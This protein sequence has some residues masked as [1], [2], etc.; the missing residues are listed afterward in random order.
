MSTVSLKKIAEGEEQKKINGAQRFKNFF[1]DNFPAFG[2][3]VL[4]IF[5]GIVTKG[6][7]YSKFNVKT[8]LSQ[9]FLYIVGGYGCLFLYAQGGIDL[10]MAASIGT[11]AIVGAQVMEFNIPLGIAVT[12]LIGVTVGLVMGLIYAYIGIPLFIQGLAMNFLLTGVLWPLCFGRSSIPSPAPIIALK[13]SAA[14]IAIV[15]VGLIIVIL[16]YNYTKFGKEC[17]AMG[18]GSTSSIQ[19]GVNV[20]KNK[21]LAFVITGFTCGFVAF[22][23]LCRTGAAS[24]STGASFNFN[25]MLSLVLGGC[26][27]GGG[28]G[29]KVKNAILGAALLILLQNGLAVWGANVRIQ[30]IVK[31]VMFILMIVITTKLNNKIRK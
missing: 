3:V 12:I 8:M 5:F 2:L 9:M 4:M 29:V 28:A 16:T 17:R 14:E 15:V 23:T 31:G 26:V 22:L 13:S 6:N 19:S 20:K 10:S 7:V 18:A 27:M 21:I 30:E 25:V 1:Y 24:Q 11:C